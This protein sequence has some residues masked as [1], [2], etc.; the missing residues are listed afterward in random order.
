MLVSL[1]PP[2]GPLQL[3]RVPQQKV[4]ASFE[5]ALS[6]QLCLLLGTAV[7]LTLSLGIMRILETCAFLMTS[8]TTL[9]QRV[10]L[11]NCPHIQLRPRWTHPAHLSAHAGFLSNRCNHA[12]HLGVTS[13]GAV[14]VS[15]QLLNTLN[16]TLDFIF[17]P[18]P[19][20]SVHSRP[21]DHLS[22]P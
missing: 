20:H 17:S 18:S 13:D 3:G 2:T 9:I 16:F 7:S 11:L 19:L 21:I 12:L 4:P 5:V 22:V 15:S 14:P 6:A 10:P 1:V 8:L